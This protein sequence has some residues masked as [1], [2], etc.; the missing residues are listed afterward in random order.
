MVPTGKT[1]WVETEPM[2]FK[3]VYDFPEVGKKDMYLL[4]HEEIESLAKKYS[5]STEDPFLY[6]I[7]TELSDTYEMSGKCRNAFHRTCGI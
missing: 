6:D 1:D 7:R 2:E 3:S 4:H 5:G